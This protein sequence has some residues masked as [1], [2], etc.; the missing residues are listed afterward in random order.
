MT[1]LGR[2]LLLVNDTVSKWK[3]C[4]KIPSAAATGL[5]MIHLS[6][7]IDTTRSD[8][9][10]STWC[11]DCRRMAAAIDVNDRDAHDVEVVAQQSYA[12]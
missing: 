6:L 8:S 7:I 5:A 10:R 1:W 3:T 9:R 11:F 4:M 12:A 2:D